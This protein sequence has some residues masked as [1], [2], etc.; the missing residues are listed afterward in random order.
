MNE[1]YVVFVLDFVG[2]H[3]IPIGPSI[4]EFGVLVLFAVPVVS[5]PGIQS[6]LIQ[7]VHDYH[8]VLVTGQ[9]LPLPAGSGEQLNPIQDSILYIPLGIECQGKYSLWNRTMLRRKLAVNHN[10]ASYRSLRRGT[11]DAPARG[12]LTEKSQ[13]LRPWTEGCG[14]RLFSA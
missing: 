7:N 14:T 2:D 12:S 11:E 8:L 3:P 1:H 5:G 9:V 13:N 10:I 6:E 4:Y